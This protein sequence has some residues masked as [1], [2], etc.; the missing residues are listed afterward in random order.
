VHVAVHPT[1]GRPVVAVLQR[2]NEGNDPIQSF[3]R[4]LNPQSGQWSAAQQVHIG[5]SSN[6]IGALAPDE[7][8]DETQ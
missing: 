6:G 4:V 3:V 8:T 7:E 2:F 1:Q 5:D